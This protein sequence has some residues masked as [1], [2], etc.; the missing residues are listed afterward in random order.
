MINKTK[1]ESL[2]HTGDSLCIVD[3]GKV[4]NTAVSFYDKKV[5]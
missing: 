5:K 2:V 4:D 1:K 3:S